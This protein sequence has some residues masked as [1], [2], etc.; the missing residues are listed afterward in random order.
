MIENSVATV[1]NA[2][3]VGNHTLP[4]KE[5]N[6]VRVVTFKDIDIVHERPDGTA[7]KR[8]ND[9]KKYFIEGEDFYKISPSEFRTAIGDMDRRQQNDVTLWCGDCL[10]LMKDIPDKSIDCV[11]TDLPYGSTSCSWDIIIPF[12]NMWKQLK[13]ITKPTSPIILFGQEPFTSE[14]RISNL[15]DYKYDIYWEKE[16]L[17]NIQQVK[18]RI[19]K[20]VETI[21]I[22]YE[23]QPTYNPQ[24]IKYE[25]KPRSNKVKDGV[26][27]KLS[28]NK[29]H[30]VT[31]YIDTG[32]R[33]PTQ[34]WKF[35][36]DCLKSNFHPTQ[37]PVALLEE[38][39]KTFS[40]KSD[41][42]L[43][44][45]MGSGSTGVVCKNLGRR[46]IGIELDDTYFEIAKERIKNTNV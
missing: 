24:M 35:Q 38:L 21:S 37:K 8:F 15:K 13:R 33:Y 25:G 31:E 45:T 32:W 1:E 6:N 7:R 18:R 11:I 10:E 23:K 9:N 40:N 39:I 28:D 22:F 5:Y 36:R 27:G 42:I 29:E 34:V 30:K 4:I 17:T 20:T 16:R 43:D 12:D 14:L 44:F 26:I 41:I 2:I 3:T 19:G 46:F